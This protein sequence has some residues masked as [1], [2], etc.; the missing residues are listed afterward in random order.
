MRVQL[1]SYQNTLRICVPKGENF[2]KEGIPGED[3][4]VINKQ[5]KNKKYKQG[6]YTVLTTFLEMS[7]KIIEITQIYLRRNITVQFLSNYLVKY[8]QNVTF[9]LCMITRLPMPRVS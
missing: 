2:T 3:P 4:T 7:V 5:E 9:H 1:Y 6:E 8:T